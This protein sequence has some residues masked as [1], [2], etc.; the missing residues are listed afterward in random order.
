M[1]HALVIALILLLSYFSVK[2]ILQPGFFPMHD[3]TQVAR[4][5]EMGRALKEGQFP[6]RW[7][8]DLGYGY[9]YPIFNFYGPLPYYVGGV[10]YAVGL[11]GLTATKVMFVVGIVAVAVTAYVATVGIFGMWG[12]LTAALFLLFAPYHAVQVY[13]RGAVGEYWALVFL[14]L[15]FWALWSYKRQTSPVILVGGFALAGVILSHTLFGFV[16]VLFLSVFL[17]IFWTISAFRHKFQKELFAGHVLMLLLGLGLSAFFWLPALTEM[18]FTNVAAQVSATANYIDHFV[19]LGQ[20]WDSPW[21]FGGSAP[22]CIDGFSFKLGKL[23]ILAALAGSILAWKFRKKGERWV[24]WTAVGV[25][26]GSIGLML[27]V[28]RAL[29]AAIPQFAYVQYPWRF[30]MGAELGLSLLAGFFI[31]VIQEGKVKI[32]L[33]VFLVA[34]IMWT[35][36]KLFTPQYLYTKQPSDF[37]TKEELRWRVSKI[38]DEYLPPALI[39]PASATHVVSATIPQGPGREVRT[40]KDTATY[41]RF[42]ILTAHETDLTVNRAYFP[43]WRYSVN[44][45]DTAPHVIQGLPAVHVPAG[46]ST[47]EIRFDD[48]LP[49]TLGNLMSG[50]T[51]VL[52]VLIYGYKKKA[53]IT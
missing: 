29:W 47:L 16:T 23:H 49:R 46:V 14:P 2:P 9:G 30:L 26:V 33:A 24:F 37:E 20:L 31:F 38:S 41:A 32:A 53:A 25:T 19:C 50:A 27:P 28:S 11:S 4:V 22:G 6:V 42:E 8:A 17:G 18:R 36:V 44:N 12:A 1:K 21:G 48:T 5:V 10:L 13:V 52:L 35:N 15:L 39:R 45:V 51:V 7:V 34:W 40:E 43:G 3:D